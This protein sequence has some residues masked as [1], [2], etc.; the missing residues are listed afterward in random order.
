MFQILL[1]DDHPVV[2][3]GLRSSL[4]QHGGWI[5]CGEASTGREAVE[6]AQSLKPDLAILDLM[7][8]ELDGVEATRRIRRQ[9]PKTEILIF[10]FQDSEELAAE[11]LAAGARGFALKGDPPEELVRAV[12]ALAQHRPWF[13]PGVPKMVV[14]RAGQNRPHAR[15]RVSLL[16]ARERQIVQLVAEGHRTRDIAQALGISEKTVETHRAAVMRKLQ[17]EGLADVV[18][19]AV[20]NNIVQP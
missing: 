10:T 13:S 9:L 3:R 15:G 14:E 18:R 11:A 19:F 7:M 20:R 17:L 8:P 5:I 1:A 4:E 16:T 6:L 2:R 12:E